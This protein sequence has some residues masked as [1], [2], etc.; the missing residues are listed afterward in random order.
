MPRTAGQI[1]SLTMTASAQIS[2]ASCLHQPMKVQS[3]FTRLRNL[4][5]PCT[6]SSRME[7]SVVKSSSKT[8]PSR[9]LTN[10]QNH[11]AVIDNT[12]SR[13]ILTRPTTSQCTTLRELLSKTLKTKRLPGSRSRTQ[14]GETRTNLLNHQ[15]TVAATHAQLLR[16][17]YCLSKTL[18]KTLI[19]L[20]L[21]V[22]PSRSLR[23]ILMLW[24][25]IS[26]VLKGLIGSHLDARN[27]LLEC[28]SGSPLTLTTKIESFSQSK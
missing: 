19:S 8:S 3:L 24:T 22:L 15:T 23:E 11:H 17:W 12:Y 25:K 14:A 27:Q 10:P 26:I 18:A 13:G 21:Q 9:T 28:S 4:K 5:Y 7:L 6:R 1:I 2:S 20:S 16:T